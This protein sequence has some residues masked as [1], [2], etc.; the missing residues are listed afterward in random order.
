MLTRRNLFKSA[1]TFGLSALAPWLDRSAHGA[2]P[3]ARHDYA[4]AM[5]DSH[6]GRKRSLLKLEYLE[7]L[8]DDLDC[9]EVVA[10]FGSPLKS[11]RWTG[12]D[13][14]WGTSNCPFCGEVGFRVGSESFTCKWCEAEGSA[15]EFYAR[16]EG[17]PQR[18]AA[19]RLEAMLNS[20]M[21]KGRR[22]ENEHACRMLEEAQ[23]FYHELLCESPEG[24]MARECLAEQ[25]LTQSTIKRFRL[26]YA[27]LEPDNLLSRHLVKA[28]YVIP[29][30]LQTVHVNED[31]EQKLIDRHVGGH[32][33]IP[34][35]DSAGRSWGFMKNKHMSQHSLQS[36]WMQDTLSISERRLR[37]LIFPHPTWPQDFDRHKMLLVAE[38]PW[39]VVAL[40]NAGIE[41]VVYLLDCATDPVRMRTLLSFGQEILC[42]VDPK[43]H[44][45]VTAF[46]FIERLEREARQL[47]V[48]SVPSQGVLMSLLRSG[49]GQAVRDAMSQAIPF[50][51]W[52]GA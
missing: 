51:Q 7:N 40:H 27:P 22:R 38:T 50:H 20:G 42:C 37:R 23:R 3:E 25:G 21:L 11:P 36:G 43:R 39:E 2:V 46:Q 9:V 28:G 49:G 10:R 8:K 48:M 14:T 5:D 4:T 44:R 13:L 6:S 26:G 1:A 52:W 19:S 17:V 35:R 33:L 18:E 47:S 30:L 45:P 16:V 29:K 24:A 31:G 41:N 15:I 12:A 34:I 32:L